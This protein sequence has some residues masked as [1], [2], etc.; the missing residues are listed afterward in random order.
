MSRLLQIVSLIGLK[1]LRTALIGLLAVG[2]GILL[3]G[4]TLLAHRTG[5]PRLA[6]TAAALSLVFVVVLLVFVVPPLARN[7]GRE[8]SEL[9]LPFELTAGGAI[10]AALFAIVGFSAWNT[11]NNLL[12]LVLAFILAAILVGFALG[13][14]SLRKIEVRMRFPE[15]I[16]A[17]EPTRILINI[18]NRKR[19][20]PAVSVVMEVRGTEQTESIAAAE[21]RKSLPRFIAEKMAKAPVVRKPLGHFPFLKGQE[22]VET[23]VNYVFPVRGRFL[24]RDF[25]LST[26]F[27]FSFF[28]HRRRLN[29]RETELYVF[30]SIER[31]GSE[32]YDA[33]PQSG[34]LFSMR[35]GSG[36]DLLALRQYRP[37]DD[38]RRIDWKATARS[39]SLIVKEFAAEDDLKASI[40]LDPR[41]PTEDFRFSGIRE[42]LAAESSG[43]LF[44]LSVR[45]E[46]G[47]SL[48]ASLLAH[49]NKLQAETRLSIGESSGRFGVGASHLI[50]SLR[51][52]AVAMPVAAGLDANAA[53]S[54]PISLTD[55]EDYK[56]VIITAFA[57]Y[58]APLSSSPGVIIIEY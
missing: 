32:I 31:L 52:L 49:L 56:I 22:S 23:I 16:F 26:R 44:P 12:F 27:P 14:L 47:V 21:Y 58:F 48:A 10:A 2:A 36:Q 35:K 57:E 33:L 4:L 38:Q 28:C 17:G 29:A 37:N 18:D 46:K 3:A 30:P 53:R 8:A 51:M 20:L 50:E 6:F 1:D 24:I 39:R 7:A 11:G 5:N 9:N 41:V 40:Y 43:T 45:F 15:A 34:K 13:S 42:M 54:L 25:E 19:I 55:A